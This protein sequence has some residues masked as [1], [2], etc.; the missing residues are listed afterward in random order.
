MDGLFLGW[1]LRYQSNEVQ[2]HRYIQ[3]YLSGRF[4]DSYFRL[5]EMLKLRNEPFEFDQ[6]TYFRSFWWTGHKKPV[7]LPCETE[8]SKYGFAYFG[9]GLFN[10]PIKMGEAN[11][12]LASRFRLL[13]FDSFFLYAILLAH[14]SDCGFCCSLNF[15]R[16][17]CFFFSCLCIYIFRAALLSAHRKRCHWSVLCHSVRC[18][19][20]MYPILRCLFG[21]VWV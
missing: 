19:F 17:E 11:S 4:Y 20:R 5:T 15:V 10:A 21:T 3:K 18:T 12:T 9:H 1:V 8:S 13:S 6:T 16:F 2:G 14:I 7:Y